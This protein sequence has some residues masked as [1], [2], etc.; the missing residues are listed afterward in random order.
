MELQ[1]F[2]SETLLQIISG[3]K[4]AQ[5]KTNSFGGSVNPRITGSSEYAAQHGFLRTVGGGPAQIVQ[6]DV[7][8]TVTEGTGTKGGIGVFAGAINLGSSGQSA[9]ENKS[10][11]RVKFSVPITLPENQ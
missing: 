2:V 10:I 11:S 3:V 8:L 7:A 1:E 5:E 6:F 4:N 9:N